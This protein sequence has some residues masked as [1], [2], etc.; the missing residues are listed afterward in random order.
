MHILTQNIAEREEQNWLDILKNAV[1]DPILLLKR[2]NLSESYFLE[3]IKARQ[4]FAMRVPTP[5]IE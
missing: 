1:S 2:L 5:F 3:D 4:L